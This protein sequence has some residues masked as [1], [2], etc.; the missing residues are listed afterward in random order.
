M[1]RLLL[2]TYFLAMCCVAL[3]VGNVRAAD[4]PGKSSADSYKHK[5]LKS[6]SSLVKALKSVGKTTDTDVGAGKRSHGG[7]AFHKGLK[8]TKLSHVTHKS[9]KKPSHWKHRSNKKMAHH[10]TAYKKHHMKKKT[11]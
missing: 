6:Y 1:P 2:L 4:L 3:A 9:H 11:F 8:S 7:S 10:E 5:E